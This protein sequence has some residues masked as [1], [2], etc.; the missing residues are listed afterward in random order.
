MFFG[1]VSCALEARTTLLVH[2]AADFAAL[3]LSL[4][5]PLCFAAALLLLCLQQGPKVQGLPP[6]T[7]KDTK[8]L[9]RTKKN[10]KDK[11]TFTDPKDQRNSLKTK[12]KPQVP[13]N[14]LNAKNTPPGLSPQMELAPPQKIRGGLITTRYTPR[15]LKPHLKFR[16][17]F[18]PI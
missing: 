1:G 2:F 14:T 12:K 3:P 15:V 4:L 6:K 10:V 16:G 9:G 7:L 11:K 13:K 8:K 17:G 18:S 5:L